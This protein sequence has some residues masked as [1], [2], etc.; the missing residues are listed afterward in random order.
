[1]ET[2]NL[3]LNIVELQAYYVNINKSC[4]FL[5]KKSGQGLDLFGRGSKGFSE[6]ILYLSEL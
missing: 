1:M 4:I 5:T 2:I 6:S 3:L